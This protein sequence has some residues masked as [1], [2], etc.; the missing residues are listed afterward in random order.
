[1][2]LK[3]LVSGQG[4]AQQMNSLSCC[5]H[6]GLHSDITTEGVEEADG[7]LVIHFPKD[8]IGA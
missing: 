8:P 4:T 3:K 2:I 1:M 6:C 5:D 7:S